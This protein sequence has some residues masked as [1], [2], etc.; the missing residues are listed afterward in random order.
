MS[1]T[2]QEIEEEMKAHGLPMQ[3]LDILRTVPLPLDPGEVE[4]PYDIE[5]IPPE[6]GDTYV[7]QSTPDQLVHNLESQR[8]QYGLADRASRRFALRQLSG[9]RFVDQA[10][11]SFSRR[12]RA[13]QTHMASG[14]RG[15]SRR[16]LAITFP[17]S[18]SS[19]PSVV[20]GSS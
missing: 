16:S 13:S 14:L 8:R 9:R 12:S 17:N 10:G 15:W 4:N 3:L 6:K 2:K 20:L 5:I 19:V 7:R 18:I 1:A 11:V